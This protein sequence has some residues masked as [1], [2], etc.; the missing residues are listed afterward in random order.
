MQ[1]KPQI[2]L[3]FSKRLVSQTSKGRN[4][5]RKLPTSKKDMDLFSHLKMFLRL[6][7]EKKKKPRSENEEPTT[8]HKNEQES[9]PQRAKKK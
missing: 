9:S 2:D 7:I 1:N 4:S 3:N 5:L 8:M 6:K